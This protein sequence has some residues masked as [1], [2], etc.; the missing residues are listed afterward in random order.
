M[1]CDCKL[2]QSFKAPY[3]DQGAAELRIRP[4]HALAL[5][6]HRNP[7]RRFRSAWHC[8]AIMACASVACAPTMRR[9]DPTRPHSFRR[10]IPP[11]KCF[12]KGATRGL[13][14]VRADNCVHRAPHGTLR[15]HRSRGTQPLPD[16]WPSCGDIR[17]LMLLRFGPRSPFRPSL[18]ST[19]EP[20]CSSVNRPAPL[21]RALDSLAIDENPTAPA[22]PAASAGCLLPGGRRHV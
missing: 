18:A 13:P 19:A 14:G 12:T 8:K 3:S 17:A 15:A 4:K 7:P 16:L 21:R 6:S 22:V 10:I 11:N 1:F 2:R 5:R 9:K 20:R